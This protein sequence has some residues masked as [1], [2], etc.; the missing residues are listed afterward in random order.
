MQILISNLK[1]IFMILQDISEKRSDE[2]ILD[3]FLNSFRLKTL[4][5]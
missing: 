4:H 2:I 1:W 3:I 5:H